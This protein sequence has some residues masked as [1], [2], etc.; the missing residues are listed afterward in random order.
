[1]I[2]KISD[3]INLLISF[4]GQAILNHGLFQVNFCYP[5]CVTLAPMMTLPYKQPVGPKKAH[6][7]VRQWAND[8][9]PTLA[10]RK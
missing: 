9:L 1:M 6:S 4:V 8:V 7:V 3:Y 5:V 10:Q 2:S